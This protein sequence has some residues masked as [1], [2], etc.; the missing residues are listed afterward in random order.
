M[1]PVTPL[2]DAA[3]EFAGI[4]LGDRRLTKRLVSCVGVVQSDPAQSFPR[5]FGNGSALEGFYRLVGNARVHHGVLGDHHAE[6]TWERALS[7]TG[8]G[9][10]IVAHDTTEYAFTNE[11]LR[12]GLEPIGSSRQGFYGHHALAVAET[13]LPVV[14]G[15]LGTHPYVLRDRAWH[16]I[17]GDDSELEMGSG[18]DRWMWLFQSVRNDT[19]PEAEVVHVMDREGDFFP[20]LAEMEL[21]DA[22]FVVRVSHN[23][24]VDDGERLSDL[25][26]QQPV[27]AKR[28]VP[29]SRRTDHGRCLS[30]KK[31]HLARDSRSA[32]LSLRFRQVELRPSALQ[33][34]AKLD[35][36]PVKLHVVDV[37]EESPPEDQPAVHWRLYTNLDVTNAAEALRVVDIYRRRW[38][39]EEF[40]KAIKTGCAYLKRQ[41]T[42]RSALLD[43]LAMLVPVAVP[44]FP[45]PA[46]PR[47]PVR[48]V[49]RRTSAERRRDVCVYTAQP[50]WTV[51]AGLSAPT[52][53]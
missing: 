16:W 42:T 10:I 2:L 52:R 5:A 34:R 49:G 39:I 36:A 46:P 25:L 47:C 3:A 38:L 15:V 12:E 29:L 20:M 48:I 44:V 50:R 18:S 1:S 45:L 40:F 9:A 4:H 14:H 22:H 11:F 8:T 51:R 23:R 32:T 21:Q 19:P 43:T 33:K 24:I 30:A 28:D 53:S 17:A 31:T 13:G 37:R 7:S 41:A 6:K 35:I 26:D 27:V